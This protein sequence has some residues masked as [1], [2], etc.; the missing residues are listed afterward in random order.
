MKDNVK[1]QLQKRKQS[2]K[3]IISSNKNKNE[4]EKDHH[5]SD[6]TE[7]FKNI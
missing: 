3:F 1:K 7:V 4:K 2:S 5:E 6:E